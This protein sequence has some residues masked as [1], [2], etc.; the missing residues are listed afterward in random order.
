M[1][2]CTRFRPMVSCSVNPD[3][4]AAFRFHSV[5]MPLKSTPKIGAFALSI[6][7]DKP[8]AT[9]SCSLVLQLCSSCTYAGPPP[10][11][12]RFKPCLSQHL[13]QPRRTDMPQGGRSLWTQA[14][15]FHQNGSG[16]TY[17]I[18]SCNAIPQMLSCSWHAGE[19]GEGE[20]NPAT[21]Y[22]TYNG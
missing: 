2:F 8:S 17:T 20:R 16:M 7:R 12:L 18:V 22:S 3:I 10:T 15:S 21:T 14:S 6:S 5:T 9:R 4:E 1:K 11:W 19:T 13:P